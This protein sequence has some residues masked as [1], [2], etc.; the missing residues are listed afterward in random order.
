MTGTT[1]SKDGMKENFLNFSVISSSLPESRHSSSFG[2]ASYLS[3]ATGTD[4]SIILGKVT[5][6]QCWEICR[7]A[8][9]LTANRR[10]TNKFWKQCFQGWG[11]Q[12]RE[13]FPSVS[14]RVK[15]VPFY[16]IGIRG[17]YVV[18]IFVIIFSKN[19]ERCKFVRAKLRESF[20]HSRPFQAGA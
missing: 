8:H 11:I 1:G 17:L 10:L 7:A 18:A 16:S 19:T 6:L 12:R 20:S 13:E 14:Y 4:L 2:G 15:L 9:R 5:L 3:L